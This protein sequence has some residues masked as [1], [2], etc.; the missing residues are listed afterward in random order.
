MR[1]PFLFASALWPVFASLAEVPS[2]GLL[3]A[4]SD[5]PFSPVLFYSPPSA[6]DSED[7]GRS[8]CWSMR[9]MRLLKR[10]TGVSTFCRRCSAKP[11]T[12]VL[13]LDDTPL[14][15]APRDFGAIG[16]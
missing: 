3:D 11:C 6:D 5:A 13:W 15:K 8:R 16:R 4:P 9:E 2:L 7:V 1:V 12:G 10:S 14:P